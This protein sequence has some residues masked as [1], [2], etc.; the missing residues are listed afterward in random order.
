MTGNLSDYAENKLLNHM[1]GVSTF[2]MPT[3][4]YLALFTSNP[5]DAGTGTEVTGNGYARKVIPFSTATT[6]T[7]S[8]ASEVAF[9]TPTGAW[10]IVTHFGIYDALTG[11]NLLV[12]GPLTTADGTAITPTTSNEF[13]VKATKLSV[14][15]D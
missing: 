14:T 5:T 2:T 10:G 15:M 8:N 3:T 1:L 11:G 9:A 6:G 7:I 13:K 4:V 12:H